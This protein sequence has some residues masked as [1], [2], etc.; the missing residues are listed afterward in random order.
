[1]M[2]FLMSL[3]A[4]SQHWEAQFFA[5]IIDKIDPQHIIDGFEINGNPEDAYDC[6]YMITLAHLMKN[7]NRTLQFHS[8][9][10]LHHHYNDLE[11]L[12]KIL[13]FYH[14]IS[15]ILNHT[16]NLVLHPVDSYDT[17][18]AISRTHKFLNNLSLLKK[19]HN[20]NLTFSLENLNNTYQHQR[21]NTKSLRTLIENHPDIYF[22]WDIGHEVSEGICDYQLKKT[23]RQALNN[24]H[25]H[26]IYSKDHY[27][28][29]YGMTDYKRSIDYLNS[30]NY[31]GSLVTEINLAYLSGNSLL[32]KFRCYTDNIN[33]LKSYYLN[34]YEDTSDLVCA[35]D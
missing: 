12:N 17:E 31:K 23:M 22:C 20:F 18:I 34:N 24:V 33:L 3:H 32:E 26:D 21:L 11:Y 16:V 29:T 9:F 15:L 28:F 4:L 5:R 13:I 30:T 2:K 25:I 14:D 8:H 7:Y 35:I 10:E 1:M 6:D 27:P 19:I